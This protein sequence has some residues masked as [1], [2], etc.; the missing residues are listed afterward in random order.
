MTFREG[1]AQVHYQRWK[2]NRDFIVR[3]KPLDL[4]SDSSSVFTTSFPLFYINW[5]DFG[6]GI[7]KGPTMNVN[8]N[9]FIL[10][11]YTALYCSDYLLVLVLLRIVLK[12][13]MGRMC[14]P[15]LDCNYWYHTYTVTW[16]NLRGICSIYKISFEANALYW[17]RCGRRLWTLDPSIRLQDQRVAPGPSHFHI[18][19]P[20]KM[21]V[22]KA[23]EHQVGHW[24]LITASWWIKT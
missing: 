24:R 14:S 3:K 13:D 1:C 2:L 22:W 11:F 6:L 17:G 21:S 12:D 23:R 19:N 10:L 9:Q 18:Y 16:L 7:F 5:K 20:L 15:M 4:H 8:A